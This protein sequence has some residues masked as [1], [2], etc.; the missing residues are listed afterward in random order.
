MR[1]LK[2]V[3]PDGSITELHG[4][5]ATGRDVHI[6]GPLADLLINY[7]PAG[8]IVDMVFPIVDVAK[9]SD[10]YYEFTQADLWR[11]PDTKRS[12]L[13]MAKMVDLNVSTGT[14]FAKNYALATGVSLEDLTNA[15]QV[16]NLRQSK[17][18]FV[19]DLLTLDWEDR[20]ATLVINSANVSTWTSA[21][22][23]WSDTVNSNPLLD[24]DRAKEQVRGV[25]G[26]TPNR[27]VF[28]WQAWRYFKLNTEVRK[29]LFPAANA[30]AGPGIPNMNHVK[31]LFDFEEVLV[32]GTMKNTAA[33][34]LAQSLSDI[35]GPHALVYYAPPTVAKDRPSYG[36]SFR[37]A[38][39]G[40]PN[41]VVEN[42]GFDR[43]LKGEILEIGFYQDEK[44][45]GKN[46]ASV[47]GSVIA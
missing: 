34:G 43:R 7:R 20:V 6:D 3:N 29:V 31:A 42:Y 5:D 12:P 44:I 46:F 16:L 17:S 25:T 39:P 26:Y 22:S 4:Y 19:Q 27:I 24:I 18:M 9:Q 45:T 30:V 8:S 38:R 40:L 36:Y 23:L 35:W 1:T 11:I 10:M 28:G 41:L 14:Y 2:L 37:W 21:T 32:G 15:D 13:T 47:V 33:E